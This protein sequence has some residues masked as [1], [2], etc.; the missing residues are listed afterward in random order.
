[1]KFPESPFWNYSSQ[2]FQI[3]EVA[4]ACLEMQNSFDAD[5]NL[6]LFCCWAGDNH[7]QLDDNNISRLIEASQPWQTAILKP[8]RD[9]RKLMKNNIIA[10]PAS[11]HAQTITNLG[12]MELNAEHMAQL[13][14]EKA[15]DF[16]SLKTDDA[17]C[18]DMAARNL[19]AYVQKLETTQVSDIT[20]VVTALLR[21]IYGDDEMVQMAMLTAMA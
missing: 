1:M 8:L 2:L 13:S 21:H 19:M 10:M 7:K 9:A 16:S 14:L 11:L 6:L 4:N 3:A 17:S 18:V 12:E 20:G 5:V 15:I